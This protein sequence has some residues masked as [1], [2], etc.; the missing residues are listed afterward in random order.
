MECYLDNGAT[1]AVSPSAVAA[2]KRAMEEVW[3]NPSSLHRRGIDAL[4]LLQQCRETVA[5]VLGCDREEVTFT[6][7]AT[8]SNNLALFGA[9]G[10]K[11]G[12]ATGLSPPP[13]SIPR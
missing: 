13:L 1:T 9:A 3:G 5:G 7:G 11:S 12:G 8:E 4:L 2:A 6:S 10:P